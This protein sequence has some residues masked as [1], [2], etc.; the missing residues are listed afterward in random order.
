MRAEFSLIRALISKLTYRE[1]YGSREKKCF[2]R[3]G[4]VGNTLIASEKST[5]AYP[6]PIK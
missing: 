5:A 2:L 4:G 1:N 6:V 3:G